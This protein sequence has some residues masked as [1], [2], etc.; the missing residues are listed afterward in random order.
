MKIRSTLEMFLSLSLAAGA[1]V[2]ANPFGYDSRSMEDWAIVRVYD[3]ANVDP[4]ILER[5]KQAA[6]H[7]FQ[8]AGVELRW[9]DC[10][11]GE[12]NEDICGRPLSSGEIAL[13]ILRR[14]RQASDATGRL[15]N[16][17]AIRTDSEQG[18]SGLVSIFYERTE[19]IAEQVQ[20]DC[21]QLNVVEARGIVLGHFVAHEIGHILLPTNSHSASGIMKERLD[22]EEWGQ[23]IRG[24]LFFTRQES[25]LI[26]QR[27]NLTARRG[28]RN[29]KWGQV[30]KM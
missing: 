25:E 17:I 4:R 16:G 12:I 21:L 15:T 14:T 10:L 28:Q 18:I 26:R 9:T 6:G 20:N 19:E 23:A 3:L 1:P 8:N 27:L 13:R 29:G 2:S 5:A 30:W 22:H 7:V 11:Q 24:I